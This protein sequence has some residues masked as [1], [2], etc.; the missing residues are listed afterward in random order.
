MEPGEK[1]VLGPKPTKTKNGKLKEVN[2]VHDAAK[3]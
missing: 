3:Y 2:I 1:Y